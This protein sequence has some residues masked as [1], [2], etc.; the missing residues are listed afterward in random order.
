[1]EGLSKLKE[2]EYLNLAVNSIRKI[3]GVRRCESL[4][5]LDMT[6]NFVDVE[7]LKESLDELEYCEALKELYMLGNPCLEWSDCKDYIIARLP[8]LARLEGEDITRSQKLAA[9]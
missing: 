6:L 3:E 2:L 7:D 5:K 9:K 1:M 4:S 8:Q